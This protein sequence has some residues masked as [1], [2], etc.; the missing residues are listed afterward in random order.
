MQIDKYEV[1]KAGEGFWVIFD[2]MVNAFLV[3]G[4][5]RALLVDTGV[6]TGDMAAAV[7]EL[8]DKPVF[9]ANTH[10]DDDHTG[11]NRLFEE[12][13]MHPA[14]YAFYRSFPK[15][16][17]LKVAPLQDGEVIDLG[18]R[19]VEV[20]LTPG[21]TPGSIAFLLREDRVLLSG[22][23]VS[24]GPVFMFG[25][26]RSIEAYMDSMRRLKGRS[27][28]FDLIYPSHGQGAV[29]PEILDRLIEAAGLTRDGK[30][31]P[32]EPPFEIPAK[33]YL[34]N[35]VGFFYNAE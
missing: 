24:E 1:T 22:D 21:H 17:E 26:V 28:E 18:G 8:T 4:T 23:G 32:Q 10:A 9:L 35:G 3:E 19:S 33:M 20:I 30:L 2:T 34:H 5:E 12:T 25:P 7:R 29:K 13:H 11:C 16:R 27:G 6:G 31:E 15:C 14:E